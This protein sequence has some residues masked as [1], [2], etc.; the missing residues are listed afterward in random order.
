[1][2]TM[3]L[4]FIIFHLLIGMGAVM[5]RLTFGLLKWGFL[6]VL[7]IGL[8]VFA[9]LFT[10]PVLVLLPAA[11]VLYLLVCGVAYLAR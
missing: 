5:F 7:C 11:L 1:M 8:T 6:A 3:L 9:V 4:I 2:L 10:V